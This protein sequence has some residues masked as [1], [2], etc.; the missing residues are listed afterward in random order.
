MANS[1]INQ[2]PDIAIEMLDFEPKHKTYTDE[3]LTQ[4][5]NELP[6]LDFIDSLVS[7]NRFEE[8]KNLQILNRYISDSIELDQ[9]VNLFI[10]YGH[11]LLVIVKGLEE[12]GTLKFYQHPNPGIRILV[13]SKTKS[14]KI[15]EFLS[16]DPCALVRG[17]VARNINTSEHTLDRLAGQGTGHI[18]PFIYV[19]NIF[20][21]QDQ[22]N[23]TF[24]M[25]DLVYNL[26]LGECS[27]SN[28]SPNKN[29]EEFFESNDLETPPIANFL[30]KRIRHYGNWNWATQ[31]F[32]HR[33][34]DY[35]LESVEYLKG[36]IPDQYSLNHEGHGVNSYALNFRCAIGNIAI[37]AQVS[38]GGA[39]NDSQVQAKKWDEIQQI[40]ATILI[41]NSDFETD[42]IK[43]RKFL[44]VYSNFR[45]DEPE[46]WEN[47]ENNWEKL[48][49]I[50][51]WEQINEYLLQNNDLDPNYKRMYLD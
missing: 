9:H 18:D 8:L 26:E 13:A 39:Y 44:I 47:K 5:L 51:N 48:K 29:F 36:P 42:E 32:P 22:K 19:K 14:K 6:L 30:E 4:E 33:M 38:W 27:C 1:I 20:G 34:Q 50:H 12:Y 24:S 10:P 7:T 35:S 16:Y 25:Q 15:L 45:L 40:L 21:E 49:F 28:T 43:T 23:K 37:M 17:E 31:P 41:N 3:K 2:L 11:G 46:L